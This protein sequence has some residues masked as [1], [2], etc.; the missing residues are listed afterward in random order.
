MRL[1]FNIRALVKS[2][3]CVG[4][5]TYVGI[6]NVILYEAESPITRTDTY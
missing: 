5:L 3:M 2:R 6:L 1:R 4:V